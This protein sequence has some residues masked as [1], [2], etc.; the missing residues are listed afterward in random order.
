MLGKALRTRPAR[1]VK[2][3]PDDRIL[4]VQKT[5]AR[6]GPRGLVDSA[7]KSLPLNKRPCMASAL[8]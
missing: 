6:S 4:R 8:S 7:A 2:L 5:Q 3:H 1:D